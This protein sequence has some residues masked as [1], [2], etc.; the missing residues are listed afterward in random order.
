MHVVGDHDCTHLMMLTGFRP[1]GLPSK[2]WLKPR[3]NSR[4]GAACVRVM[5][6]SML[7]LFTTSSTAFRSGVND[8]PSSAKDT[9]VRK[10]PCR[11]AQGEM[12]HLCQ[13]HARVV[14]SCEL[15]QSMCGMAPIS[16]P[17][18]CKH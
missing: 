13:V 4:R 15:D 8:M 17:D 10:T 5:L 12:I 2:K 3:M 7:L 18:T 11:L 1:D 9:V 16:C 6:P 14:K